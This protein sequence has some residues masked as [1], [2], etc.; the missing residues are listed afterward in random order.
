MISRLF[1]FKNDILCPL[2]LFGAFVKNGC[3]MENDNVINRLFKDKNIFSCTFSIF[4]RS[5]C[6][7]SF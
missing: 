2:I 5:I 3:K 1:K 4:F 7:K 6:K